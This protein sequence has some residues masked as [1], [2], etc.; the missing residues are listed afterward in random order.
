MSNPS[1]DTHVFIHTSRKINNN[2][3]KVDDD[4]DERNT[5]LNYELIKDN[6]FLA[7][8]LLQ[9]PPFASR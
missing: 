3:I 7:E 2:N 4:D 1:S 8:Y 5:Y 9:Q 6:R